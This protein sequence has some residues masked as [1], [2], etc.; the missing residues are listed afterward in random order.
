MSSLPKST[1]ALIDRIVAHVEQNRA[2]FESLVTT[3]QGQIETSRELRPLIHSIK[4]RVKDSDHL[5]NKLIKKGL[6]AKEQGEPFPYSL[7]NVFRKMNDI[8]G[9]RIIHLHTKQVAD[10]NRIL[11]ELF[12]EY[13]WTLLEGPSARTWDDESRQFFQDLGFETVDSSKTMYTS[14]HYVIQLNSR[15]EITFELQVRTLME[16]VWGEVDH[17]INYPKKSPSDSCREQIKV[18]ARVTSSASRLVDSIFLAHQSALGD[19]SRA[20]DAAPS[21]PKGRV[22]SNTVKRK[23]AKPKKLVSHSEELGHGS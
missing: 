3:F 21:R 1:L 7:E 12:T 16:E 9:F 22:R 23:R 6:E 17:S 4:S 13:Q 20:D 19:S 18:L 11:N 2:K 15:T 14:V 5:R 8:A 10:I